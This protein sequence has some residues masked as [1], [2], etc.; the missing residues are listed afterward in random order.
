M[1]LTAQFHEMRALL[2]RLGKST[3]LLAMIPTGQP[4]H[5]GKATD[6]SLAEP[7]L[8]L[9]KARAIHDRAITSRIS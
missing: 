7:R 8:E 9:V 2:G 4:F 3:P 6:Q 1:P 5:M